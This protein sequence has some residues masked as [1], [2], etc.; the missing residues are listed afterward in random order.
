MVLVALVVMVAAG[1]VS[2]QDESVV[3]AI[4]ALAWSPSGT[5]LAAGFGEYRPSEV[6]CVS[7]KVEI[8]SEE[9]HLVSFDAV[10]GCG[11][12]G[13]AFGPHD[14]DLIIQT[15]SG[16]VQF[17]NIAKNSEER[18]FRSIFS[19][20]RAAISNNGVHLASIGEGRFVSVIDVVNTDPEGR[21]L[22]GDNDGLITDLT[23]SP[24]D[25]S[26]ALSYLEGVVKIC[27]TFTGEL[28]QEIRLNEAISKTA[29]AWSSCD[30]HIAIGQENGIVLI[31]DAWENEVLFEFSDQQAPINDLDWSPDGTML[32]SASDDGTVRVWNA[33]SGDLLETFTYTGPVYALDWSPDGT[34][35]AFGGA[36]TT[37]SP[38]QVVIVDAPHL[39]EIAPTPTP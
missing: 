30:M 12:V 28:Q 33:E 3:P 26:V 35:I 15:D 5:Y 11:V 32:A 13:V 8:L 31:W 19:V 10:S 24:N 16:Y 1:V 25:E 18:L 14:H 27:E 38:P 17:W 22:L 4:T 20:N 9:S 36:D 21:Q 6:R 23:W 7:G 2:G 29:V 37:G 39:P 34:Q